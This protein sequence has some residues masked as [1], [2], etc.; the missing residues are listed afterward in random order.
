M[1]NLHS[2]EDFLNEAKN[3]E[4]INAYDAVIELDAP[5]M[6][7]FLKMFAEYFQRSSNVLTNMDAKKIAGH[8][9][10]AHDLV[11]KRSGN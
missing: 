11:K 7:E 3:P 5:A 9:E 8:L 4:V 1:K 10:S 6:E 2:F